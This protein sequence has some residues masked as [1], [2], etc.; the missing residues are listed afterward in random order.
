MRIFL[1]GATGV[2]GRRLVPLLVAAGHE[3]V[4]TTRS[5]SKAG[6]LRAAGAEPAVLD[7]LDRDAVL[8]AVDAAAPDVVVHQLTAIDKSD[9]KHFDR[10]FALTNRLRTE[11]L[12]HLLAASLAA[13][14]RRFVA[15]NFI[16]WSNERSGESVKTE[17]DPLAAAPAG[18]SSES[19]AAIKYIDQTITTTPG[20]EGLSL[21]YGFFYGPGT[22]LGIG[23]E[24]VEMVRK[25]QWPIVGGGAA[26]WSLIHIDD[27][28]RATVA[29]IESGAPGVYNIVDDDPAPVRDV[30]T[31]L[32]DAIGAKPPRRVPVWMAR[33]MLGGFG[34]AAMT[35]LRGSSNAKAKRELGW[36]PEYSSWREGFRTALG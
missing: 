14:A 31:V 2:I 29:A 10:A 28:A 12:D 17:D 8:K 19:L 20:I 35:S 16:G 3:V 22:S 5:Q 33:P 9:F 36:K 23:G 25:R 1:A 26:I 4:G 6:E 24:N 34:V 32:A 7:A 15:Q 18:E 27:A 13:G 11:G 21:R 30:V